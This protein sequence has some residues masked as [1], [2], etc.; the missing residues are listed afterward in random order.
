MQKARE[1]FDSP[2]PNLLPITFPRKGPLPSVTTLAELQRL[3]TEFSQRRGWVHEPKNLSMSIAI[4][5]AELMEHYQWV[6]TGQRLSPEQVEQVALESADILWY[7]LRLAEN[8]GFDLADALK[9][10]LAINE[11]RFPPK[12]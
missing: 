7:L 10:K 3:V 9:Q 4:E 8:E 6:D 12:S 11:G 1:E 2:G 5:A